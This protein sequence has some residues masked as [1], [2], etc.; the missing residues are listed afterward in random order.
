MGGLGCFWWDRPAGQMVSELFILQ[1]F[2]RRAAVSLH[3]NS[4]NIPN[5]PLYWLQHIGTKR[6]F[7]MVVAC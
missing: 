2:F 1:P 3:Y 4:L 5:L 7:A 6:S